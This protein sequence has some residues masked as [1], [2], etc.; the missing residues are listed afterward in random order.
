VGS[1]CW[2]ERLPDGLWETRYAGSRFP[3]SPA[4]GCRP[5]LADGANCQ[6][7]AYEVLRLFGYDPP[8]LRSSDLWADVER[9]V[10]VP[11]ARPFDLALFGRTEDPW[12][13]HVGVCVGDGRALHLCAEVGVPAVWPIRDFQERD[14][15]RTLIGF[16]RVL[17]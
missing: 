15:Y 12:G 9:T 4:V 6:L 16:K 8:D 14:R 5:G 1:T 10:R 17:R 2:L 11:I 7:F 3:G 13:A